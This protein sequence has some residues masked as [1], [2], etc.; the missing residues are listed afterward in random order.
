MQRGRRNT[1]RK[2]F[3]K[4]TTTGQSAVSANQQD[5]PITSPNR[6]VETG[7][8]KFLYL[9]GDRIIAAVCLYAGLRILIFAAAF[10]IFNNLDEQFHFISI[11]MYA[12]GEWPGKNLPN[13]SRESSELISYYETY[14]YL[15]PKAEVDTLYSIP[16]YRLPRAAGYPYVERTYQTW[17]HDQNYEAQSAPLY[18][19]VGAG[20]L[21][22]GEAL[23]VRSW[24]LP[25]W[26]R[27]LNPM[28]YV[29]LIWASYRFVRRVYPDHAF[30][31]L[32]VPALLAVFP[33]DVYF[34][35]NREVFSAPFAAVALL[36]MT[37]TSQDKGAKPWLLVLTSLAVGL[38]FLVDISNCV[39]YG[40]FVL[41]LWYWA[42]QS[43][44]TAVSKLW[45]MGGSLLISLS[46][47]LLWMLRNYLV[48]GDVTAS[49]AK[50]EHLTWT[51]KPL[52]EIFHHPIFSLGGLSYF[53]SNL[54]R[55]FW[56]GEYEWHGLAMSWPPMDWLYLVS[57]LVMIAAFAV[58]VLRRK[59][60]PSGQSLAEFQSLLL[61]FGSVFFMAA[62]SLPYDFQRCPNPSR[63]H[64]FFIS[65]RIISGALL[66]FALV[67]TAGIES[68]L[69]PIRKWI[70]PAAVLGCLLVFVTVAEFQVRRVAFSSLHNFFAFRKW[71]QSHES[72]DGY[73]SGRIAPLSLDETSQRFQEGV[74]DFRVLAQQSPDLYQP[75][76]ATALSNLASADRLQGR[77][78]EA[79]QNYDDSVTIRRQLARQNP[80]QYLPDV[81]I[82]LNDLGL[83]EELQKHPDQARQHHEEA[84]KIDRELAQQNPKKYQASVAATLIDL[85][86]IDLRNM[87]RSQNRPGDARQD[88]DEALKIYQ[89]LAE[90]DTSA[91]YLPEML[92]TINDLANLNLS[93]N[94]TDEA[95]QELEQG[96][97]IRR[98]LARQNPDQ[99]L[100]DLA[101]ALN[102]AGR[103]DA[104]QKRIDD[105]LRE[106][107]EALKIYA[108]LSRQNPQA[109][110][111]DFAGTLSNHGFLNQEKRRTEASRSDYTDAL[112]VYQY[113]AQREPS[114]YA[115]NVARVQT[116]LAQL[117]QGSSIQ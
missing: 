78:E 9:H 21:R 106:V 50:T 60:S 67:Y 63:E 37:K 99:Y 34:G 113:L 69:R 92:V 38:T 44:A 59:N 29:L 48:I 88:F 39:L 17:L 82:M 101:A 45:T 2:K 40:A 91:N 61:I 87:E 6:P 36:L 20:W 51:L 96:L 43:S 114:K 58:H 97:S 85:G 27:L 75:Y 57:T 3:A 33:Q 52:G 84:L 47:P 116:A 107:D 14:E 111:P 72:P 26:I 30:L 11:Q 62:I 71:Q 77:L 7:F 32:G 15:R 19:L 24:E 56:R 103:M 22:V 31:W 74:S 8:G 112:K 16:Y 12:S 76:L 108:Q 18:Y 64:P 109:Y 90:Q 102:D 83:V 98:Q 79:R 53:L 54:V 110:L 25:Y 105:A 117:A 4:G 28:A 66:P 65:G 94:H 23:G 80:E 73:L 5:S 55:S 10:P 95:R 70:P 115:A 46:L 41:M 86:N 35:I 49:R 1:S 42:K 100:P 89:Q 81:A 104:T 93:Q 13:P 68:L